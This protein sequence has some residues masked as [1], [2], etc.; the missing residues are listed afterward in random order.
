MQTE[1]ER[2][3]ERETYRE[4][5]TNM[6]RTPSSSD[7]RKKSG[8]LSYTFSSSVSQ[9]AATALKDTEHID[10]VGQWKQAHERK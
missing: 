10:R 6:L 7:A 3:I 1:R 5:S 4:T 9:K 2:Q 8:Y